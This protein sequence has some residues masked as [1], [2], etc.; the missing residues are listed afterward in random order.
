MSAYKA[1]AKTPPAT[2]HFC[3][4]LQVKRCAGE[5]VCS[6]LGR[7]F[8]LMHEFDW[9][10]GILVWSCVRLTVPNSDGTA[11]VGGGLAAI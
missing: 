4:L 1:D 8:S 10:T 6:S 11:L 3:V 2:K 7:L 9:T 5:E